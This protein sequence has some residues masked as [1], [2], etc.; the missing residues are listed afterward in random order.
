MVRDERSALLTMRSKRRVR[1]RDGS[2]FL[3]ARATWS[4]VTMSAALPQELRM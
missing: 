3:R 4:A 2:Y 1:G